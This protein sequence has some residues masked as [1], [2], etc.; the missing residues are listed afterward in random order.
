MSDGSTPFSNSCGR[1]DCG[2]GASAGPSTGGGC[3]AREA[4][5]ASVT[6]AE[7]MSPARFH[8]ICLSAPNFSP[9]EMGAAGKSRSTNLC[10]RAA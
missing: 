9:R 8:L 2:G 3:A 5:R 1:T 7:T 4:A 6:V 10:E